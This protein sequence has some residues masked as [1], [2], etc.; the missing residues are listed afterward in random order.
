MDDAFADVDALY[1][2]IV[3]K[4]MCFENAMQRCN[5]IADVVLT[6]DTFPDRFGLFDSELEHSMGI[7]KM[8]VDNCLVCYVIDPGIVTVT[9]VLY[10]VSD[11]HKRLQERHM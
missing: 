11:V 5:W 8:V 6:L 1:E 9:D 3:K 4:L 10:G 7:H 2:Y